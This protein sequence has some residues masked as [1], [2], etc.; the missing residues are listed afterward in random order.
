MY[1]FYT[2]INGTGGNMTAIR[3]TYHRVWN[4][5]YGNLKSV[6]KSYC[7]RNAYLTGFSKMRD[8]H[9]YRG[10]KYKIIKSFSLFGVIYFI[11]IYHPD[12]N[13]AIVQITYS[14]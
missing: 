8:Y 11:R 3:I 1:K 7:K 14:K 6:N 4:S 5:C 13:H 12:K 10:K 9:R 2:K